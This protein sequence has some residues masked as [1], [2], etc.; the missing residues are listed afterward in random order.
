M[1]TLLQSYKAQVI[2]LLFIWIVSMVLSAEFVLSL[3][4]IGLILLA[5]F[6]VDF[7]GP[8]VRLTYRKTLSDQF[9]HFSRYKAWV[10]V[11]LPFIIVL[12]S[13]LWSSDFQY[14][15]ERL[16]IKLPFLVLPFAFASMPRLSKKEIFSI[17]Y[18]LLV[19]MTIISLYILGNFLAD[20]D[21][22]ME[23]IRTG[24]HMPTPSNHIRFSLTLALTIMGGLALWVDG[25]YFSN[26]SE[27]R[28]IA[29]MTSFLFIFIHLLSVRSGILA[30]YVALLV[31]GVYFAI[32]KKK[33]L[34]GALVVVGV[35]LLP[36]IAYKTLPSFRQKIDY[37]RWDYQQYLQG[38]GEHYADSE[39]L[40]SMQV[41]LDIGNESPIFGVG[42]GDVRKKVE[43]HYQSKLAGKYNYRLPHNQ[44]ITIY[45]G[46]GLFGVLIFV[47]GFFYPLLY[48]QS[49]RNPVFLAFHAIILMSFMM[50]NTIENNFGVSLYLLFLLIGLNFISQNEEPRT[51]EGT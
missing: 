33:Y 49:F 2:I 13:S 29:I 40:I 19:M 46:S 36:L 37:A 6:Q 27:K 20:Y 7:E 16:R 23:S 9:F 5:L 15:L 50:E 8:A 14:T 10:A 35:M 34:L 26:A 3:A 43:E 18:F 39:R 41:G 24:G 28:L 1:Q 42:A 21:A 25:F 12:I 17:V 47:I 45:A 51:S 32:V 22:V 31:L 11:M 30:L 4:M 38:I 44:F 48:R